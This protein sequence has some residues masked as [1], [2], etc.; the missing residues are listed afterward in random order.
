MFRPLFVKYRTKSGCGY[1]YDLGTGEIIEVDD[2]IYAIADDYRLLTRD[3]LLVKYASLGR[4]AVEQALADLAAIRK[5]GCLA[6]HPP[7]ELARVERIL[8]DRTLYD[9]EEFWSQTASLLILGT[10]ERCNLCCE[11]C[12]YRGNFDGFRKHEN[13]SMPFEVAAKAVD[14]YLTNRPGAYPDLLPITFYGGEPLL[15][16]DL[17]KRIVRYADDL[18]ARSGKKVAY[19]VTTNGTLLD[20]ETVDYLV[21]RDIMVIVSFDGAR[22]SHDRYR[23]FPDGAGSFDLI[24]ANLERFARRYPDYKNRGINMV[25][26]PPL[27]L[28]DAAALMAE[29]IDD[30]PLSRA[31]WVNVG[32]SERLSQAGAPATRYGCYS[33]STGQCPSAPMDL[34]AVFS[35]TD[36]EALSRMWEA[37]V[38]S[39]ARVGLRETKRL[40]PLATVLFE[41]QLDV[42]H[43]RGIT[44]KKQDWSLM[45]PCFPGF[46]R[47]FCDVDGN[48]RICE[49]VDDSEAFILGNVHDGLQ[50][51]KLQ[52]IM[53]LRR[54]FGDCANCTAVKACD[55][56]YARIPHT[57]RAGTG[58]D[59]DF[60]ALCRQTRSIY[61]NLLLTYTEI[62]EANPTA[63]DKPSWANQPRIRY[64][65]YPRPLA[66][67][68]QKKLE[69]E[70]LY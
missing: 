23:I 57:D 14:D 26:A 67:E 70:S 29:I 64:G 63:L 58:Y 9:L 69:R 50:T 2:V 36:R 40:M 27:E 12:C 46:S 42:L 53:E 54:H 48:Y 8:F 7:Q 15:E 25:V 19:S 49:R 31:A 33:A 38:A 35:D 3:E 44:S 56:C 37:C 10:T 6:D 11:Y 62:L 68:T 28:E 17:M 51:G 32:P 34:F 13:R 39:L 24:R 21:G 60:D 65:V 47:R 5:E 4:D 61:A 1:L 43:N 66:P 20:D 22:T 45:V 59:P 52:R 30:Y 55:L 41:Q 18:A 16:L